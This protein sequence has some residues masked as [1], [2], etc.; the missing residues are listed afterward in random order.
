MRNFTKIVGILCLSL[1]IFFGCDI[2][3]DDKL[4]SDL[5]PPRLTYSDGK[6][7]DGTVGVEYKNADNSL[8]TVGTA[9]GTEQK[10]ITYKLKTGSTLPNGLNPTMIEIKD[11]EGNPITDNEGKLITVWKGEITGTP[12]VGSAINNHKFTVIA[13][14][15]GYTSAEATFTITIED[16]TK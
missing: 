4:L 8:V 15:E 7:P 3:S 1:G 12:L 14:A 11:D 10:N 2:Y 6:L 13:S 9:K 5:I 16:D